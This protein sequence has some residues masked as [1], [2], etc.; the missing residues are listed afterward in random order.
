MG[1]GTDDFYTNNVRSG[2]F[3]INQW[4]KQHQNFRPE[5]RKINL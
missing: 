3:L 2:V 5:C 4:D 1:D